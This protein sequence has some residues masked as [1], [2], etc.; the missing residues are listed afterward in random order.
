ML[1][2]AVYS[3]IALR[4]L[5]CPLFCLGDAGVAHTAPQVTGCSCGV[6]ESASLPCGQW[7]SDDREREPADD[8]CTTGCVCQI[9]IEKPGKAFSMDSHLWQAL[10]LPLV[11]VGALLTPNPGTHLTEHSLRPDLASGMAIRLAFASLLL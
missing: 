6:S 5:F 8:P 1:R 10:P 4:V 2:N 9:L 7:P 11:D 3:I